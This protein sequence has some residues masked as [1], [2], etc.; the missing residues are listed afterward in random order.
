[1]IAAWL[2][3]ACG[4]DATQSGTDTATATSADTG[5]DA[6]DA[7]DAREDADATAVADS[8]AD[9]GMSIAD[10]PTGETGTRIVFVSRAINDRG[11]IYSADARDLPGVG[12]H[13]RVR[14]AAPGR[15][16]VLEPDL[17]ATVLVDGGVPTAATLDLI[18]VNAPAVSYDGETIVFAGLRQGDWDDAPARS[19]GG[20]RLY[21]I[22]A[23]GQGLAALPIPETSVALDQFGP[24]AGGLAGFDDY[25]PVFLPDGRIAFSSTRWPSYG[26]YSGVRASNLYVVGLDGQRLVRITA[27]RNGADRPLV[28]PLTGAIV[29][30]RWWRNHRFPI[31]DM[32]AIPVD[33]GDASKGWLQ[34]D[35][36]TTDR[37][38]PVG[39]PSMFR[40]AWQAATIHP[41]GTHLAMWSGTVRD[42]EA[43]HVYG[44]SFAADGTLFAN[45][46]PMY[47]MTEASGFGGVRRY[48]RGASPYTAVTGIT[49]LT[50]A[51]VHPE[52]P[53]S[54]GIFEGTYA[55]DPEVL[56]DGRIVVSRAAG[57]TQDYG[58]YVMDADG[59]N[60]DRLF[61]SPGMAD[62]RARVLAPRPRPPVLPDAYRDDPSKPAPSALPPR[63]EGPFTGDGTFTFEALNVYANGPVDSDI[64]SAIPV[65]SAGTIR[66]F[67]DPQ[68]TSP[69]SFPA[70]DWPILL[71]EKPVQ[72]D[73]S[74]T[75]SAPA[76]IPLFEQI[77]SPAPD[78]RVPRT[79]GP[80]A[81][82]A[83][84]V[85]GMNYGPAGAIARC[86]GCHAGHTMIP[87]PDD[88][89][90]ARFSNL[91]PGAAVTA[92]SVRDAQYL[93]AVVDRRVMRGPIWKV[94]WT[95]AA[96]TG[97]G[98]WVELLF[99]VPVTVREVRLWGIR[100]GDEASS[101]V[102]VAHA[103]VALFTDATGATPAAS[104]TASEVSAD[105]VAVPF[106]DV[107]ARR[108]RVTIDEVSGTF[109]GIHCAGLGEVE[110]I[111]RG[112][113]P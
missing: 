108:V 67:A 109:Y 29:Y 104:A 6:A 113:A 74:V 7:A 14:P 103:T 94:S 101:S 32:T 59:E 58:L 68:R 35:G 87:I 8:A 40:N 36:L 5:Q 24:A 56:P 72:P 64:V 85:A 26:Q 9:S 21:R 82:G 19:L 75:E 20:W 52:A 44:G 105:S 13:S 45:F 88:D 83:A 60:I 37:D 43:N 100:P 34:K 51:Y 27:E 50:L 41:D 80:D 55:T 49:T 38:D 57:I 95:S 93:A 54:Y 98:Q 78:Y 47:N 86:V 53:T 22:G 28:D 16:M 3:G 66:F 30:A 92:S 33:A 91:A 71:G 112:E 107:R 61:D 2:G 62:L 70:L 11:S 25:D 63:A 48:A 76:D 17:R 106:A 73:G 15:L 4:A 99:P 46:F 69:G 79:G 39:G 12:P 65:G 102:A 111:A 90:A 1:M 77:R 89:E 97:A 81:D 10:V 110:V 42:E 31:D 23:D 84:H 96:D 18:D